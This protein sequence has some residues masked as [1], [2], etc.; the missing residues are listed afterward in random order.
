MS[1]HRRTRIRQPAIVT[2]GWQEGLSRGRLNASWLVSERQESPVNVD[3]DPSPTVQVTFVPAADAGDG[4]FVAQIVALV[5]RVYRD[6]E[7]GLWLEGTDRTDAEEVAAIV[8]AGEL[9]VAR[10]AGRLVGAVRVRRLDDGLGEFGM[11]VASPAD[12]GVGIGRD[13]VAFAER[14]AR[15][16]GLGRMQ[17]E[18]LVPQTW[19]HPVK[20]F[21]RGWYTRIGYRQVRTSRLEAAY[22]ALQPRL[23]TPCDFVIYHKVL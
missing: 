14:W 17:L 3:I 23:A 10:L 9:V 8:D 13:L 19:T 16:Q 4:E 6:A 12:R 2:G 20:E 5:N 18:L 1:I 21:L 15:E 22:P 11:L 7:K